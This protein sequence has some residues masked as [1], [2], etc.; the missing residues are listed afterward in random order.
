MSTQ[1]ITVKMNEDWLTTSPDVNS[2]IDSEVNTDID[3][4]NITEMEDRNPSPRYLRNLY[5]S[6]AEVWTKE[7]LLKAEQDVAQLPHPN[8]FRA[9]SSMSFNP[10]SAL[11]S[12]YIDTVV[13]TVN[14]DLAYR[15]ISEAP[16]TSAGDIS[17]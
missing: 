3:A 16:H 17:R 10:F 6:G 4:P 14:G 8:V 9:A 12:S 2:K 15:N 11:W 13:S 7:M 5:E 1:F